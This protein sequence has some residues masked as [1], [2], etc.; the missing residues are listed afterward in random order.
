MN[1][2]EKMLQSGKKLYLHLTTEEPG[3]AVYL[4][5]LSANRQ[6]GVEYEVKTMP[7]P[8]SEN[9]AVGI[10]TEYENW[11]AH[12]RIREHPLKLP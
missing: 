10:N 3:E 1:I 12:K 4:T 11:S 8:V 9:T 7:V 5:A 2:T 6:L